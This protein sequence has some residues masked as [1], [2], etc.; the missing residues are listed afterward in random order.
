MPLQRSRFSPLHLQ[1]KAMHHFRLSVA[2]AVLCLISGCSTFSETFADRPHTSS[3]V[4][5]GTQVDVAVVGALGDE[6]AGIFRL[7]APFALLDLPLSLAADTLLLPY[8]I[9]KEMHG[10]KQTL[11]A[12]GT[13]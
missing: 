10:P 2:A 7:F 11:P 3:L 8:T 5:C 9:T 4:Y 6:T 12:K 1:S 13:P